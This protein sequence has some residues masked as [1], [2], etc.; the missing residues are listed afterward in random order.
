MG[1]HDSR[2]R[3]VLTRGVDR[4]RTAFDKATVTHWY[5]QSFAI[6][7]R[8][9]EASMTGEVVSKTEQV[10]RASWLYQW[11]TAEPDSDPIVI[12]LQDAVSIGTPLGVLGRL[13]TPISQYWRDAHSRIAFDQLQ[14][15]VLSRPVQAVSIVVLIVVVVDLVSQFVLGNPPADTIGV[16]LILGSLALTG[17]RVTK[18]VDDLAQ[19]QTVVLCKRIFAP[20]ESSETVN[21]EN[22]RRESS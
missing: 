6:G 11:S 2:T 17:T 9:F 4:V 5:R 22:E 21:A 3:R 20:P 8:A 13:L 12:D 7:N 19:M 16:G 1:V 10:I 18:S 14:S 15:T